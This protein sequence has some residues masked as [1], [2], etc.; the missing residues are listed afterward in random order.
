MSG[1]FEGG[2]PLGEMIEALSV[3][4]AIFAVVGRL[5][6]DVQLQQNPGGSV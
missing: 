2:G 3:G 5:L 1:L 6:M 4:V